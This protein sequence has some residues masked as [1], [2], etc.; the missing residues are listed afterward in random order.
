MA[1]KLVATPKCWVLSFPLNIVHSMDVSPILALETNALDHLDRINILH[2][3]RSKIVRKA[4]SD[5]SEIKF[6]FK[7]H[8]FLNYYF[9]IRDVVDLI[10]VLNIGK[11]EFI[12]L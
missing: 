5:L 2:T 9:L 8:V 1:W 11:Y 7:T 12:L 10:A 6:S 3:K 4:F